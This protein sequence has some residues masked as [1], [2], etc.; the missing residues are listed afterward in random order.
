MK[1]IKNMIEMLEHQAGW[2][3]YTGGDPTPLYSMMGEL[4]QLESVMMG[5]SKSYEYYSACNKPE[6]EWDEYD[7]MMYPTWIKFGEL[8]SSGDK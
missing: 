4:R 1:L 5:L 6:L 3:K 2:V 7:Y 8:I